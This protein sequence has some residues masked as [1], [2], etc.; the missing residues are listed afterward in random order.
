MVLFFSFLEFSAAL[1]YLKAVRNS[2][3]TSH[4][5]VVGFQVFFRTCKTVAVDF[6]IFSDKLMG[7]FIL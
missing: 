6:Y 5:V 7:L 4:V 3:E 1:G 2:A